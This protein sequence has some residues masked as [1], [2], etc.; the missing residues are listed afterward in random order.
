MV[1]GP[2]N[3]VSQAERRH[4]DAAPGL[5][6]RVCVVVCDE[7]GNWSFFAYLKNK[8]LPYLKKILASSKLK[9]FRITKALVNFLSVRPLIVASP[10]ITLSSG[11]DCSAKEPHDC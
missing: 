1:T 6:G 8:R 3:E 10:R 2:E 4:I 11:D 7:D 9:Q 5:G